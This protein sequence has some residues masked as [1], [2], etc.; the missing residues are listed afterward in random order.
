M[1]SKEFLEKVK[2]S[3]GNE[4]IIFDDT[5]G[6]NFKSYCAIEIVKMIKKQKRGYKYD[7]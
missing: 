2:K 7:R 5:D 6:N 1:N 4:V 3:K